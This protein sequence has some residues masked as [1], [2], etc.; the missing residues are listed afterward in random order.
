MD[1]NC[2]GKKYSDEKISYAKSSYEAKH[3]ERL[4]RFEILRHFEMFKLIIL[5]FYN[6]LFV[7]LHNYKISPEY[8]TL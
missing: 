4:L 3:C 2:N 6:L 1:D 5:H 7:L 8:K